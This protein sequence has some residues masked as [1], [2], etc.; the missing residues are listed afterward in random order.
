MEFFRYRGTL[1][2]LL[3]LVLA[4]CNQKPAPTDA[5]VASEVQSKIYGDATVQSRTIA[6]QANNGVVTLNGNV[7]ND[8]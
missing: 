8:S 2:I 1:S 3:L 5:Q 4:G 7:A 6:V